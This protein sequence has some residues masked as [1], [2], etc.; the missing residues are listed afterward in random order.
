MGKRLADEL[1]FDYYDREILTAI[2]QKQELSEEN[3]EK[4]LQSHIWQTIP[5]TFHR[6]FAAAKMMQDK[7]VKLMLDQKQKMIIEKIARAGKNCVIVGRNADVH[8]AEQHPLSIFVCAD[9]K[10]KIHRCIE[11]APGGENLS[12]WEIEQYIRRIN[13]RRVHTREIVAN[14]KWGDSKAYHVTVNTTMWE[15]KQLTPAVAGLALHWFRK[16]Q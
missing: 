1:G 5:L 16:T 13:K 11:C 14:S 12:R 15:I 8:L 6:S 4:A 3:I 10:S 9:M 2:A 7:K